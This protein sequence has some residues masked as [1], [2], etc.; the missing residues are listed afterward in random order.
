[1]LWKHEQISHFATSTLQQRYKFKYCHSFIIFERFLTA[2][3]LATSRSKTPKMSILLYRYNK[4][5]WLIVVLVFVFFALREYLRSECVRECPSEPTVL[6]N[7][8]ASEA[9]EGGNKR[10]ILGFLSYKA[11]QKRR[12]KALVLR[13]VLFFK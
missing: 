4:S 7:K 11:E 6:P 5:I 9:F 8:R 2:F 12:L 10:P 3:Q 1:M 13:K